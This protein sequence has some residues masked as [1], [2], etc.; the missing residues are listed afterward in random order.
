MFYV[1]NTFFNF[2]IFFLS[3]SSPTT[4]IFLLAKPLSKGKPTY[5]KPMIPTEN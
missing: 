2:S 1:A 5:P 4:F 3:I